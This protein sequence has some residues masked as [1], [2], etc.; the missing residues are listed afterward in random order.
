MKTK[1]TILIPVFFL[2]ITLGSA[3]AAF[4]PVWVARYN[5]P[6]PGNDSPTAMALDSAGN[7][8]VV[9]YS[10]STGGGGQHD[11]VSIKYNA[12]GQGVWTN[13]YAAAGSGISGA[14]RPG[15][16]VDG[17]GNVIVAGTGS[18]Y[19]FIT[20]K[21]AANGQGVWTNYSGAGIA[22]GLAVDA[23]GN[24]CVCG[25]SA[26]DYLTIKYSPNGQTAWANSYNG[27]GNG[28]DTALAVAADIS[29]NFY[30]TGESP[31]P[32]TGFDWVTIKYS[33]SGAASWTA[34]Q[35]APTGYD[36]VPSALAV[37]ASGNVYVT[38]YSDLALPGYEDYFTVKY[39][40]N[41]QTV[42]ANPYN[43]PGNMDDH[44]A[45]LGVDG[46]GN[47]Y[48]TGSAMN[49]SWDYTTIKYNASGGGVWTN[50][51]NGYFG[52]T[53]GGKALALD[54][55]GNVYVTGFSVESSANSVFTTLRYDAGTGAQRWIAHYG[56]TNGSDAPVAMA[57]DSAGNVYVLGR[58]IGPGTGA[59]FATLKYSQSPPAITAQ[60]QSLT[61][62][63]GTNATFNVTAVSSA[64]M[65]YQWYYNGGPISGAW[66]SSYTRSAVPC[67]DSGNYTVVVSNMF[68]VVT[69]AVAVL[70]VVHCPPII[71]S[72]PED[73]TTCGG[74]IA[75][76]NVTAT[77]SEPL[78]YQWRRNGANLSNG[79]SIN[80]ATTRGLALSGVT[81]S[82]AGDYTAV[83]TNL[84]GRA[85]SEVATLTV[86]YGP[87]ITNQPQSLTVNSG[88]PA[89]FTVVA[90]SILPMTYQ[91][92]KNLTNLTDGGNVSGAT[93]ATLTL[94]PT[95]TSDAGSYRVFVYNACY[96]VS[97]DLAQ[98]IVIGP[99]TVTTSGAYHFGGPNTTV[100]LYG[101]FNPNGAATTA[102]FQWGTTTSYG[103][104][105]PAS[106]IGSGTSVLSY[107][108][109]I[110]GLSPGVTYHFRAVAANS[111]GTSYGQDMVFMIS[112][113]YAGTQGATQ[114]NASNATF[115]AVVVPNLAQ[116]AAWFQYG[117]TTSYGYST[118]LTDVGSGTGAINVS[119]DVS[120]LQP[121]T[122]YHFQ[123][124]A[125]NTWGT[126]YGGDQAFT[127]ALV[128]LNTLTTFDGS[129]G[130]HP[131][132]GLIEGSDG[133]LYGTTYEGSPSFYPGYGTVF[134]VTTAGVLTTLYGEFGEGHIPDGGHP[135]AALL[136]GTNGNLY[137]TTYGAGVLCPLG[138][139]FQITTNG[140]L[141]N[142]YAFT[143]GTNS[144]Y[145]WADVV[146]GAD[147]NLY[148]TT[149]GY[150]LSP[151]EPGTVFALA[152]DGTCN[153]LHTF[154]PLEINTYTNTDGAHPRS[155]LVQGPEGNLY[156]TTYDGGPYGYGT[157]FALA[158]NGTFLWSAPF[159]NTNG[160]NP[161]GDL[162][163]GPDGQLYGTTHGGG[164]TDAWG[165]PCGTVFKITTNGTLTC[166]ASFD[167]TNGS[168]PCAGLTLAN[169]GCFYG[170]ASEGGN[171]SGTLFRCTP[172]GTLTQLWPFTGASDGRTPLSKLVQAADGYLYGTTA[173][174]GAYDYGTVFRFG[175]A[176][177]PAPTLQAVAQTNGALTF[178]WSAVVGMPYQVQYKTNLAQPGWLNLGGLRDATNSVMPVSDSMGPD[179]QRFYRIKVGP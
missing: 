115:K 106:S 124:V 107:G 80:A 76:F 74:G 29:G 92:Q 59:D 100:D 16:G 102:W 168:Q 4:S 31:G 6:S 160:A 156:G 81:L 75:I 125:T 51:Y 56:G 175:L 119:A 133:N 112:P 52:G 165:V 95:T 152:L 68:G 164:D 123:A 146:F 19:G 98:L 54:G 77:G 143:G 12:G 39:N 169:D 35:H 154:S 61:V 103:N 130:A 72:Q 178:T 42:W 5:G 27:T 70:T 84:Y 122:T 10:L 110:S 129:N 44:V 46:A 15:I 158:T 149:C 69:S 127:T 120:G 1:H 134:Q 57:V 167:G 50:N 2:T 32:G 157:V 101:Y 24:V 25:T 20:I 147:G 3:N 170:T 150:F 99:P 128:G 142:V 176:P 67:A 148:G 151:G 173:D 132:A 177:V 153:P 138:T 41:G 62:S 13:H 94:N 26:S 85:T 14:G 117:P 40:A 93:S 140:A 7:V 137:G 28:N 131:M 34:R 22:N 18:D 49:T 88:S 174:G 30:V 162:V 48:V 83:V 60:P 104:T 118:A 82:D 8:Y 90:S 33:P 159:A 65:T 87:T 58:S 166:L 111:W 145:P 91:W 47:V 171:G 105:T 97:S 53:D 71:T 89:S 141:T 64:P 179:Q 17:N 73:V 121:G 144:F 109:A 36:S 139:V 113:P 155:G 114:I 23:A 161:W 126:A 55:N 172:G 136:Q 66:F 21:Y 116:T 38:G 43:G 9:G 37:D 163:W 108:A 96:Y 86:A 63:A 45:G 78:G 79:G 135:M 11:L